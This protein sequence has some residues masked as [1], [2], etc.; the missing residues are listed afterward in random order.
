MIDYQMTDC[1]IVRDCV[2]SGRYARSL[3]RHFAVKGASPVDA[4]IF[5]SMMPPYRAEHI[6]TPRSENKAIR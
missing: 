3:G 5:G 2:R 4:C 1:V 6:K